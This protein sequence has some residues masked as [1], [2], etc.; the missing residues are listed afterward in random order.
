LILRFYSSWPCRAGRIVKKKKK[1][2]EK[3]GRG[4]TLSVA[5]Y[6]DLARLKQIRGRGKKKGKKDT[7]LA[8]G[9][10][11]LARPLLP[12]KVVKESVSAGPCLSLCS[13]TLVGKKK[14][15]EGK[16]RKKRNDS[17]AGDR[18]P[19]PRGH[20]H[21]LKFR[22]SLARTGKEKKR[23]GKSRHQAQLPPAS[24]RDQD[25]DRSGIKGGGFYGGEQGWDVVLFWLAH[26]VSNGK[27]KEE[28]LRGAALEWS[29]S[30]GLSAPEK[31]KGGKK[32]ER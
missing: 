30:S 32:R 17:E 23:V 5:L 29:S 6:P 2:K 20:A 11:T 24:L 14:E 28:E 1:K 31:E 12:E 9:I 3:K 25:E 13:I 18:K 26:C 27:K 4:E 22:V 7:T 19:V 15:E 16:E 21:S 10:H 8:D